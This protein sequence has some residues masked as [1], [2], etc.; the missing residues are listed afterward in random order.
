MTR[1]PF[2]PDKIPTPDVGKPARREQERHGSFDAA[3]PLSVSQVCDLIKRVIADRTPSPI[4]VAGEVSNFS[5]RNHWYLSLKDAQSVLSCVMW[6]SAAKKAAFTPK[7]GQQVVATGK[8][9]FFAPQGRLQ[10]YIDKLEPV[11]VGALELKLRQLMEELRNKGYFSEERKKPLP[12]FVRHVAVITSANGAAFADVV[13]TARQRWPGI[14]ITLVDVRVQGESAATEIARA[15]A[16]V[17]EHHER[18]AIDALILTRGGGSLEDLWAFNERIVADAIHQCRLPIVAAIGHETDT[19]I[20]ELAADLRASTPTQ[21]AARLIPDAAAERQHI[22]QLDGR[23]AFGLRRLAQHQRTKLES[24]ARHPIFRRPERM[25]DRLRDELASHRR[26]LTAAM[27]QRLARLAQRIHRCQ[28]QIARIEPVGLLKL[29]RHQ[30]QTLSRRI[31]QAAAAR[32]A[33]HHTRL[34]SLNQRLQAVG[35]VSVLDRGYSY[36]TDPE[37]K[38]IRTVAQAPEGSMLVTHL[39][40]GRVKSVVSDGTAAPRRR[41]KS[42]SSGEQGLFEDR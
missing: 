42:S 24:L 40:D 14:R 31:E 11:G 2:D 36:T 3:R 22:L 6:N 34:L 28:T 17:S 9:D 8:L 19:T 16:A 33:T 39:K 20:A 25:I 37:G 12:Q 26:Q 21:A 38:L 32:L 18:W 7:Q 15:I 41:K 29:G 5:D 23:M 35:P 4:R 30:L 10:L 27:N 1:L 13:K